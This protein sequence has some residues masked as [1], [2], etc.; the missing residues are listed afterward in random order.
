MYLPIDTNAAILLAALALPF[1]F[2]AA[3]SPKAPEVCAELRSQ[4]ELLQPAVKPAGRGEGG[5]FRRHP[6]DTGIRRI[7]RGL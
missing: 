5:I 6:D 4:V 2:L 7:A 3:P 1:A